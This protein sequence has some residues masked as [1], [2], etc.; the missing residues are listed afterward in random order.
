MAAPYTPRAS[1]NRRLSRVTAPF[2]RPSTLTS[3][4]GGTPEEEHESELR[5]RAP[6]RNVGNKRRRIMLEVDGEDGN[7]CRRRLDFGDE[8]EDDYEGLPRPPLR[9]WIEERKW[10]QIEKGVKKGGVLVGE[11]FMA[12]D[13]LTALRESL[14][15]KEDNKIEEA[16]L[17][18]LVQCLASLVELGG[19]VCAKIGDDENMAKAIIAGVE[20]YSSIGLVIEGLCTVVFKAG[21]LVKS[22]MPL[23]E[24]SIRNQVLYR[25]ESESVSPT[26]SLALVRLR[27]SL[28]ARIRV[29]RRS[30][31]FGKLSSGSASSLELNSETVRMVL[32]AVLRH[33]RKM[34]E[35]AEEGCWTLS[36]LAK[37]KEIASL[38]IMEEA[39]VVVRELAV[40]CHPQ[41][42][43]VQKAA[44]TLLASLASPSVFYSACDLPS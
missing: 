6:K 42:A 41:K 17:V 28:I 7:G 43:F 36:V 16:R 39:G 40:S 38:L 1:Y 10:K 25:L 3:S 19:D 13:G 21:L 44:V 20:R 35:I 31:G 5:V 26:T 14:W 12:A 24:S 30:A 4:L 22:P 32:A 37:N 11:Q 15:N 9:K 27:I 29:H 2:P 34:A 18:E 23:A 33:G 8:E